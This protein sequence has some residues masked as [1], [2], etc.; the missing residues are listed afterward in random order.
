M[1]NC[2]DASRRRASG[3]SNAFTM[4]RMG[5]FNGEV[6]RGVFTLPIPARKK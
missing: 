6:E 3:P 5:P 4:R 2:G 1:Y